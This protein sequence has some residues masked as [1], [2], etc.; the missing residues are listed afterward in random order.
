VN[1]QDFLALIAADLDPRVRAAKGKFYVADSPTHPYAILAGGNL[2]AWVCILDYGGDAALADAIENAAATFRATV[3]VGHCLDLRKDPGAWLY[4]DL[5]A[6][7]KALLARVDQVDEYVS[8]IGFEA[9]AGEASA[10]AR[11]AGFAA[12]TLPGTGIPLRAYRNTYS[13]EMR[14]DRTAVDYRFLNG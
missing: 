5:D 1:R 11:G 13:W 14:V 6:T 2:S 12:V 3:Y 8:G 7:R 4:T 10:Y 9:A